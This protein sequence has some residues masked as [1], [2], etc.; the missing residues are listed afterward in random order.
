MCRATDYSGTAS[1]VTNKFP[2]VVGRVTPCAPFGELSADRG[3]HGVT[4]PTR[5][6]HDATKLI[7]RGTCASVANAALGIVEALFMRFWRGTA[8][9]EW[10]ALPL[11]IVEALFMR[12]W[13]PTFRYQLTNSSRFSIS[14][15]NNAHKK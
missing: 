10:R 1:T 8:R 12:F 4:R 14:S 6:L 13:L 9:T 7:C 11:R 5:A 15:K 2:D 3:A